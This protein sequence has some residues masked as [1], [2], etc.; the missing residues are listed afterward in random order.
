MLRP[1]VPVLELIIWVLTMT[2]LAS[3][4]LSWLRLFGVRIPYGNP[5]VRAIEDTT[6]ALLR[7][8]R[9]AV[10]TTGGGFDFAPMVALIILYIIRA[11]IRQL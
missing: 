9:R 8:I 1:V 6:E 3:I 7:P 2:I 10:P 5:V 11:L 4:V